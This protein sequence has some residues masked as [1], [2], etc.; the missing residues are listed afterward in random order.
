MFVA[1]YCE[2]RSATRLTQYKNNEIKQELTKQKYYIGDNSD[3]RLYIDMRRNKGY[4]D[5]LEKLT[6]DDGGVTLTIKLK[7]AAAKNGAASY[8]L[9]TG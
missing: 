6:H 7:Q 3:E 2:A 5:K 4:T 8:C 9:F 1:Y